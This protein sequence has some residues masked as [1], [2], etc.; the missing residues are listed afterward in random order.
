MGASSSTA[1]P[2]YTSDRMR[3]RSFRLLVASSRSRLVASSANFN[4]ANSPA[5]ASLTSVMAAGWA[6]VTSRGHLRGPKLAL[7]GQPRALGANRAMVHGCRRLVLRARNRISAAD[8]SPATAAGGWFRV[9]HLD[10]YLDMAVDEGHRAR[11]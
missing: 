10:P 6:A 3:T 9:P 8:R 11:P 5:R 1:E 4:A 2:P 7:N